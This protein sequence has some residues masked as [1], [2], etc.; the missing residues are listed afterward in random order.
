MILIFCAVFF[1]ANFSNVFA[2]EKKLSIVTTIFPEY[3]WVKNVAKDKAN[4]TLLM[5]KGTDLH[6]FQPSAKDILTISNADVFIYI[7]GESDFWVKDIL[8]SSKNKDLKSIKLM[9]E[10]G[11]HAKVE[12]IV[13]GMQAEEAEEASD[14][15][16]H[17]E[18]IWLSL[19]IAKI[20]TE[21]IT[22]VLCEKDKANS[23]FYKANSA[24]YIEEIE[25]LDGKYKDCVTNAK[26]K[27]I[28]F[29]DRF[30]FRYLVDDYGIKYYAAFVGCSAETEASFNTIRFLSNK[31]E[32]EEIPVICVIENS[33]K[34]IAKR[35]SSKKI[36]VFDSLQSVTLG[37]VQKGKTY[38]AA[39]EQN[40]MALKE[41]L[42]GE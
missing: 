23:D 26:R 31:M 37:D 27:T 22:E 24:I 29:G 11:S 9:E 17:D 3:D 5:N 13:E 19:K 12:E 2:A 10:I 38:L 25:T 42:L 28:L 40:L 7:G 32:S 33:D 35:I 8:S 30:P 1:I 14:E 18:H 16:E 36:V 34:R 6:S 20:A 4:V 41:C 21:K 39:M 15:I